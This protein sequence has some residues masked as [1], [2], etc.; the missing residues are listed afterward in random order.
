M[1]PA[2]FVRSSQSIPHNQIEVHKTTLPM[3]MTFQTTILERIRQPWTA[4]PIWYTNHFEAVLGTG[5]ELRIRAANR[6]QA[7]LAE[8]VLLAEID[9]LEL[10]FSRF[11]PNSELNRF[12][13][14]PEMRV[15][16]EL[17]EVLTLAE[18]WRERT[19][20]AF[21]PGVDAISA[22]WRSGS[23]P[24][25]RQLAQI[26]EQLHAPMWTVSGALVQRT[27][28]LP[29]NF[30]AF[31]KGWI[32]DRACLVARQLEGVTDVLVNIGG[33]LRHSGLGPQRVAI[34]DPFSSIDNAPNLC[35][36]RIQNQAVAGSGNS[37]RGFQ[38]GSEWFSHEIDPRTGRPVQH[39]VAITVIAPDAATADALATAFCVLEVEDSLR[40]AD[41]LPEIACLIV[42]ENR[43]VHINKLWPQFSSSSV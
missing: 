28:S 24:E 37:R 13:A 12:L 34:A 18:S 30:N 1:V 23:V 29:V 6:R 27:S 15:S 21:H 14:A 38:I 35:E 32:A 4:S 16:P 40:M 33:D 31:A 10:I 19:R 5:L 36:V 41:A 2:A 20:S 8:A 22:L 26:L 9:R 17:L 42:S 11:L 3:P 25:S 39:T 43:Q 7:L